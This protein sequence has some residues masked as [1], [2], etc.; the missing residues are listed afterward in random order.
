MKITWLS[1][2]R[3]AGADVRGQKVIKGRKEVFGERLEG[4]QGMLVVVVV[5]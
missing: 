2:P 3:D 5:G 4:E 1:R